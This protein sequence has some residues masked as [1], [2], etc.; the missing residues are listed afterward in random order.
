MVSLGSLLTGAGVGVGGA[1]KGVR[2]TGGKVLN[3][4]IGISVG[5]IDI[6]Q[7][8]RWC[9]ILSLIFGVLIISIQALRGL[10][11]W[12]TKTSCD[13]GQ[14]LIQLPVDISVGVVGWISGTSMDAVTE[15]MSCEHLAIIIH[16]SYLWEI[17]WWLRCL[18]YMILAIAVGLIL[19]KWFMAVANYLLRVD[20]YIKKIEDWIF[21]LEWEGEA[22]RQIE[23]RL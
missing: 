17:E 2:E 13:L 23:T 7:I 12:G 20:L 21:G 15:A 4:A 3:Q 22:E 16:D 6:K 18:I 1:V 11:I 9:I 14:G 8:I 5:D 10:Q 19:Y